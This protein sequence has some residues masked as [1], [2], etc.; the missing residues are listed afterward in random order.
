VCFHDE[1]LQSFNR[2]NVRLVDTDG[3]GVD[4]ITSTGVV[5]GETEYPVDVLIFASGF[6][7]TTD[8]HQR[9]G[10]DPKGRGGVSLSEWWGQGARTLH[11][12]VSAGFPNMMM[13]GLTQAS[14]G[15]NF[16]H[17][18]TK[19]AQHIASVI[20]T[21]LEKDIA[22]FEPTTQGEE[23]WLMVLYG[24]AA[25]MNV[26]YFAGCTPGYYTSEGAAPDAK[27]ARSLGFASLLDWADQLEGWRATGDLAGTKL[28]PP[29]R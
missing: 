15:T 24:A 16:V 25:S 9:L 21:C 20:A 27:T 3:R 2:P 19:G 6:E 23:D 11:G 22:E 28:G 17:F 12:I 4:R 7:I 26:S 1:Y 14:F 5:V 13:M 10:F 29:L 18:L 8:Y